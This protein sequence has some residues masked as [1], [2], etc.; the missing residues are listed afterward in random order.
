MKKTLFIS[1]ILMLLIPFGVASAKKKNGEAKISFTENVYNFGNIAEDGGPVTHEFT[2][3]NSGDGNLVIKAANSE[4]GCTVPE[5]PQNPIAP[6][7]KGIIKVTYNPA[8]RPGG[9]TKNVTVRSNGNPAKT[10]IKIKGVVT[11]KK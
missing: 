5:Y 2:F 9:F 3:V 4:C 8:G 10:T 6:G 7:K 1:V 11:P